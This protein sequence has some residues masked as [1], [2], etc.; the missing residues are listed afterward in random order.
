M[1]D[2]HGGS[3]EGRCC[4]KDGLSSLGFGNP[5][6][7]VPFGGGARNLGASGI[8]ESLG[9]DGADLVGGSAGLVGVLLVSVGGGGACGHLGTFVGGKTSLNASVLDSSLLF[10]EVKFDLTGSARFIGVSVVG[11]FAMGI[12]S[13]GS[14]DEGS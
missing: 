3:E 1:G 2:K 12:S 13:G 11:N 4:A 9:G 5:R 14:S 8:T 10:G 6:V 7:L